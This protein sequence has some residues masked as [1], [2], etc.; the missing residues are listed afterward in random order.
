MYFSRLLT[1]KELGLEMHED[2]VHQKCLVKCSKP[3]KIKIKKIRIPEASAL[4]GK[5]T[6]IDNKSV[7][8]EKKEDLS[9]L[10]D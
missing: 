4:E 10:E 3:D 5:K 2:R 9:N 1:F 6:S 7:H 8:E